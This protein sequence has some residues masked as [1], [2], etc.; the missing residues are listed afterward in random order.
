MKDAVVAWRR[1]RDA[2]LPDDIVLLDGMEEDGPRFPCPERIESL[3]RM[4]SLRDAADERERRKASNQRLHELLN[5]RSPESTR[6]LY[7]CIAERTAAPLSA[8]WDA[9]KS[10]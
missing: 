10:C 9:A 3:R 8:V 6:M 5:G 7:R 1:I 4:L 2:L